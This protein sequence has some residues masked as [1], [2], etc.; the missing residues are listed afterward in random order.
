MVTLADA[1]PGA[2]SRTAA[3]VSEVCT[4]ASAPMSRARACSGSMPKVTGSR[5]AT[6]PVPPRPGIRPMTRPATTP[7]ASM[8]S[9]DG[10]VSEARAASAESSTVS[11]SVQ[12]DVV[13]GHQQ[14]DDVVPDVGLDGVGVVHQRGEV[15]VGDDRV[16]A[17]HLGG[18][19]GEL[20]VLGHL[21]GRA[22]Q[23]RKS[24]V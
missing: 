23:D 6:A 3:T 8:S 13:V 17:E 11:S 14:L 21:V 22:A 12:L 24:V 9:R 4:T 20:G 5:M 7:A 10:W 1:E 18:G 16:A 2:P 19:V 15:V